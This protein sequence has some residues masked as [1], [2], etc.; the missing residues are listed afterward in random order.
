[1]INSLASSEIPTTIF[2]PK[3]LSEQKVFFENK[4]LRRTIKSTFLADRVLSLPIHP[5]LSND[6][7]K[8][9]IMTINRVFI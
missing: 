9:I 8:F 7:I 2:Y 5:Y 1:M 3:A 6:E 4:Y